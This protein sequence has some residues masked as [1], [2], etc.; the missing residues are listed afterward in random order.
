MV[1]HVRESDWYYA[2]ELGLRVPAPKTRADTEAL[3]AS[4]LDVLG[5]PSDGTPLAGRRWPARYAARRIAWH[6]IDHAW[7]MEDRST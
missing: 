5:R 6:A 4:M 7:E 3:R 2:K 1:A